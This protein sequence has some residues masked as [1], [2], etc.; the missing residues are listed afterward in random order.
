[1]SSGREERTWSSVQTNRKG[2]KG[3]GKMDLSFSVV[4]IPTAYYLRRVKVL[5]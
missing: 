4:L 1:M 2:V 3:S 5:L